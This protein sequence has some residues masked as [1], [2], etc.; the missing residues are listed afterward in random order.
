MDE[1]FKFWM[2]WYGK[3]YGE[4]NLIKGDFFHDD[5]REIINSATYSIGLSLL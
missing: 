4:Y 3:E 5:H 1:K 2:K